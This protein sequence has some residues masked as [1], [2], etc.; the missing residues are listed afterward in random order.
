MVQTSARCWADECEL[1]ATAGHL[2][3]NHTGALF[4][5]L[6]RVPALETELAVTIARQDRLQ[7]AT[8]AGRSAARPLPFS[9]NGA[10]AEFALGHTIATWAGELARTLKLPLD[11]FG[12]PVA[13]AAEQVPPTPRHARSHVVAVPT[14]IVE[15]EAKTTDEDGKVTVEK[16]VQV[17]PARYHD[18]PAAIV[19][20]AG[21]AARAASWLARHLD[22]LVRLVDV[23]DALDEI[24][25]VVG[26][27]RH[28][29]DRAPARWY[30]GGCDYCGTAMYT[31]P[32]QAQ[33]LC[34]ND[35]CLFLI[36][37]ASCSIHQEPGEQ[38]TSRC[39]IHEAQ[40]SRT[41]YLVEERR[42][43][44]LAAAEDYLAT[45][46]E[47]T[48]A[49]PLLADTTINVNTL[50]QAARWRGKRP[51]EIE[52]DHTHPDGRPRYRLGDV[53]ALAHRIAE[54]RAG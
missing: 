30:V 51:P 20:A 12:H 38:C 48:A 43:W 45:A 17:T 21:L 14:R 19:P 9:W 50:R 41:S 23:V 31:R 53:L 33:V 32:G 28:V 4:K 6:T 54:R 47:A 11:Q 1:A 8:E 7:A 36:A 2:C 13:L 42:E 49:L 46:A 34:P 35:E 15:R 25:H 27:T 26:R 52:T 40:Y 24:T 39:T 10:E 29:I 3:D 37:P 5:A 44:M 16:V 18:D 22:E